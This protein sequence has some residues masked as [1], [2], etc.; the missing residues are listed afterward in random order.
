M[1]RPCNNYG[2]LSFFIWSKT[3]RNKFWTTTEGGGRKFLDLINFFNASKTLLTQGEWTILDG[4]SSSRGSEKFRCF[5]IF[6]MF[7]GILG[8]FH[9]LVLRG[10]QKFQTRRKGGGA[11]ILDR[12]SRGVKKTVDH[13]QGGKEFRCFQKGGAKIFW[14]PLKWGWRGDERF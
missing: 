6:F 14:L 8:T 9:F 7:L 4:K 10:A 13:P 12:S 3:G 5:Q 11:K 1:N 2:Y